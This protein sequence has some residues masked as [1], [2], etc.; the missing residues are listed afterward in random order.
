MTILKRVLFITIFILSVY[1]GYSLDK[2]ENPTVLFLNPGSKDDMFFTLMTDFMKAAA[3]DLDIDMEVIYCNR[4]HILLEK[5]GLKVLERERLPEYLLLINEKN[6]A[7]KL[8]PI[9]DK[10]GVKVLLFNEGILKED[11]ELYGQPGTKY[12]NWFAQ[13]LPDDFQ[14][15]YLLAKELIH[16]A[17]KSGLKAENEHIYIAGISGTNQTNSSSLRVQGLEKAISENQNVKLLQIA[18]AYYE[19]DRARDIADKFIK[20]YPKLNI[21]WSASDGIALGVTQA[22]KENN[23][24]PGKDII[25]GG[26]DWADFALREVEKNSFTATVGGHFMDGGW[27]LVMLYDY[28]N[29]IPIE[30]KS[31]KTSFSSLNKSNITK[32]M[33]K[34]G[35]MSWSE[36]NFKTYSKYLN[37][38]IKEYSFGVESLL[39]K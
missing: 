12:R 4:N 8:I 25:T 26:I 29:G 18:P 33:S 20:R 23:L 5:E 22:I 13:Y 37:P 21:I 6:G 1:S 19:I 10:K 14:A 3:E 38:E 35:S 17:E 30:N 24:Q 11:E 16:Y 39:K 28:H 31:G 32:Y 9:A 36:I 15:G 34:F 2:K 27:I 7:S